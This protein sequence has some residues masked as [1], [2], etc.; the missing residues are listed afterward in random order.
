MATRSTVAHEVQRLAPAVARQIRT[1]VAVVS[2]SQIVE[3][4]VAN[5]IDAGSTKIQV[6]IYCIS[7]NGVHFSSSHPMQVV[8]EL[9]R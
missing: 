3:E 5:A 8:V 7:T 9:G 1:D 6:R 2:P 4:L